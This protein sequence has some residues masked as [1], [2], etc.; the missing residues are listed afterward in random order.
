MGDEIDQELLVSIV[1]DEDQTLTRPEIIT[2]LEDLKMM[3]MLTVK[4]TYDSFSWSFLHELNRDVIHGHLLAQQ[5]LIMHSKSIIGVSKHR[6]SLENVA[7]LFL[8]GSFFVLAF[9]G[10]SS[11]FLFSEDL[12]RGMRTRSNHLSHLVSFSTS[13]NGSQSI[14]RSAFITLP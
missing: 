3:N 7:G 10:A 11:S 8:L 6:H 9:P 12:S 5:K 1:Q 13:Q 14:R 2:M 4:S